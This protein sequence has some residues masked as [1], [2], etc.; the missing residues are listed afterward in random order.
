MRYAEFSRDH[1]HVTWVLRSCELNHFSCVQLCVTPWTVA[2]QAPLSMEFSRQE[3]WSGLPCPPAGD[4]ANSGIETSSLT[5]NLHWQVGS[6]PLAPPGKPSVLFSCPVTSGRAS[7]LFT[8]LHHLWY[9]IP[10]ED[11][12]AMEDKSYTGILG[13]PA[14]DMVMSEL[15][16]SSSAGRGVIFMEYESS[17]WQSL[18]RLVKLSTAK[19]QGNEK[20]SKQRMEASQD[21]VKF[22]TQKT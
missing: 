7:L 20:P 10:T 4:L 12:K 22:G 3:E 19:L 15:T 14:R 5:S 2:C 9:S 8:S 21:A 1:H 11:G 18:L 6:L 17:I 13:L 16:Q